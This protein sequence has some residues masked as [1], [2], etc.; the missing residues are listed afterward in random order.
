MLGLVVVMRYMWLLSVVCAGRAAED[1]QLQRLQAVAHEHAQRASALARSSSRGAVGWTEPA[2]S[3]AVAEAAA[4]EIFDLALVAPS[5]T[6]KGGAAA[7]GG[8]GGDARVPSSSSSSLTGVGGGGGTMLHDSDSR[9]LSVPPG[10][11]PRS[12]SRS[13]SSSSS[14]HGHQRTQPE[15]ADQQLAAAAMV[16]ATAAGSVSVVGATPRER[17]A[18]FV[19]SVEAATADLLLGQPPSSSPSTSLPPPS[20]S[21]NDTLAHDNKGVGAAATDLATTLAANQVLWL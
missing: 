9:S 6:G 1:G 10:C 21:F 15:R 12:R 8:G 18:Q 16:G 17:Q 2:P 11:W 20:L 5:P 14:S 7:G 13:S 19:A 4:D 3:F